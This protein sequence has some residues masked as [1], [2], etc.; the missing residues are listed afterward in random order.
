MNINTCS[1]PNSQSNSHTSHTKVV[2]IQRQWLVTSRLCST[3]TNDGR[4]D[5]TD[6]LPVCQVML[7]I[8]NIIIINIETNLLEVFL[9]CLVGLISSCRLSLNK[10]DLEYKDDLERSHRILAGH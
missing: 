7:L 9:D 3:A 1:E 10:E 2:T 4:A 8:I 6:V 5:V